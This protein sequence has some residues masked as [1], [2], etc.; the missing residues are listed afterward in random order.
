MLPPPP[1]QGRQVKVPATVCLLAGKI[2]H[3]PHGSPCQS[4]RATPWNWGCSVH[5]EGSPTTQAALSSCK[6]KAPWFFRII[7]ACLWIATFLSQTLSHHLQQ[8]EPASEKLKFI[9]SKFVF[10]VVF[11]FKIPQYMQ[12]RVKC[13]TCSTLLSIDTKVCISCII[14]SCQLLRQSSPP[15]AQK[16]PL[17]ATSLPIIHTL[18]FVFQRHDTPVLIF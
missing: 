1:R 3:C 9:D 4:S 12:F 14:Q 11:L 10:F 5:G 13:H 17:L 6:Q 7:Q 2:R 8:E 18:E 15:P 16:Q